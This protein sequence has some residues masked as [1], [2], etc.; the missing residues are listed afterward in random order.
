[1]VWSILYHS[2]DNAPQTNS[3]MFEEPSAIAVVSAQTPAAGPYKF[4]LPIVA[5]SRPIVRATFGRLNAYRALTVATGGQKSTPVDTCSGEPSCPPGCGAEVVL[6]GQRTAADDLHLLRAFRDK[7][8]AR[9]PL[10]QRWATL[11]EEHRVD[12][13]LILMTD[14]QLRAQARSALTLW[15][16]L[17]QALT[18][19]NSMQKA[20]LT[21]EHIEAAE[22]VINGLTAKG[23][24]ELKQDLEEARQ[25]LNQARQL[26]GED[27]RE[28]WSALQATD[29]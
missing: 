5:A 20:I 4:Y 15:L 26:V 14:D 23:D 19:A 25:L 29:R 17:V 9:S 7:V 27:I 6:A 22:A 8:L 11:Y 16:P 10:G 1:V 21:D 28:V 18:D 12:V 13:A 3:A 24:P 2:A